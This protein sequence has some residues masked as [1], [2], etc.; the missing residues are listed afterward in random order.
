MGEQE[1][2]RREKEEREQKRREEEEERRLRSLFPINSIVILV[3]LKSAKHNGQRGKIVGHNGKKRRLLVELKT[4]KAQLLIKPE[5]LQISRPQTTTK[6][7]Y[8]QKF[9]KEGKAFY[10]NH[11]LGTTQWEVPDGFTY[12]PGWQIRF[13]PKSKHVYYVNVKNGS[14]Q[15]EKPPAWSFGAAKGQRDQERRDQERRDKERRD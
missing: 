10:V 2:E 13:D 15:W 9:T 8:E 4:N 6:H 11:T 7:E 3:K 12:P 1:R 5:N 14:T